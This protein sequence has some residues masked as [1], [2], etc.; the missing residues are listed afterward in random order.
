MQHLNIYAQYGALDEPTWRP[1]HRQNLVDTTL[2]YYKLLGASVRGWRSYGESNI[3]DC[4]YTESSENTPRHSYTL[5]HT[6]DPITG[7]D[8][9]EQQKCCP[10]T[11]VKNLIDYAAQGYNYGPP[12]E[13]QGV[14]GALQGSINDALCKGGALPGK[15]KG[16]D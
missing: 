13:F 4:S 7:I 15:G 12:G 1:T 11:G 16:K 5:A 9:T 2:M 14:E 10:Y 6:K 3:P 8:I